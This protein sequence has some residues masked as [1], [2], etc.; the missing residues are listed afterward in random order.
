[1]GLPATVVGTELDRS[2]KATHSG[3]VDVID[4]RGGVRGWAVN[5]AAPTQPVRLQLCIGGRT[6]AE[7]LAAGERPDIS[8]GLGVKAAVAFHF[9]AAAMQALADGIDEPGDV[10]SVRLAATGQY[11]SYSD[12]PVTGAH[13]LAQGETAP[14]PT[15]R[16]MPRSSA[17]ELDLLLDDLQAQAAPLAGHALRP[18]PEALQ[19]YIETIALTSSG[20]V[21]FMGWMQRGHLQ[22]FSA[23]VVERNKHPAAVAVMSYLRDDL[24]ADA[25]GVV[26]VIATSW[27]PNSTSS[28]VHLFFGTGGRFFMKSHDPLRM[29]PSGE[30]A[31]EYE[32]IRERCLG[33]GHA[34]ALQ[35]M[36]TSLESWQPSRTGTQWFGTETSVDR[37]LVV[38]GLGCLVEGWVMSPMKR[39]ET[40]R[41]RAGATIMSAHPD[42]LYWKPRRDLLA[43]FPGSERLAE[44]AGFVGLFTG[45][46]EPD[47]FA[48]PVLKVV[49]EGGSSANCP[50]PTRAFRRLGHSATVED[51]LLFFPAL[52]E[53][54]FFPRFAEAA[55]NA[56]RGANALPV[57]ISVVRSRRAMVF[58]L[59]ED[60]CDLFLLFEEVA[61]QVRQDMAQQVRQDMAQQVRQDGDRPARDGGIEALAFVA[62][63]RSNRSD[64]MWLFRE[65][66]AAYGHPR[67]IACSLLV[68]DD[69]AQAF[70]QLPDILRE[71]GANRFLFAGSGVFLT[72]TGWAQ[73]RQALTSGATDLVFF[74]LEAEEFE[75]RASGDEVSARCF[76]WSAGQFARWALSAP[77]FMG[78]FYR[79]NALARPDGVRTVHGSAARSTRTRMPTRT[80]EAVNVAVYAT[81]TAPAARRSGAA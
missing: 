62:A 67:S 21:W 11:L 59:P 12:K 57:P 76:V 29:L 77:A 8:A 73:A 48:D 61:Q 20:Q 36:L 53:E 7:T 15:P 16:T 1:M 19:G 18:L 63:A 34:A 28:D 46:A 4:V 79:D 38:P 14:A 69:A 43:A 30:L 66:Q 58:V 45:G 75:R 81:A 80:E 74:G 37:V 51:A 42:S 50:V 9:D 3:F 23:V 56:E 70:N 64:A 54:T 47:D 26:G 25:C 13:I 71:I 33:D 55:I 24:P 78:G 6:V 2:G 39:I 60:R 22:E 65:F 5:L 27:R 41:L 17:A 35:R 44:R 10:L 32:G 49:F 72:A 52:Q 31:T 68:I 40:L